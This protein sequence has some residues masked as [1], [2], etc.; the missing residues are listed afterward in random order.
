[1]VE[2]SFLCAALFLNEIHTPMK[3]HVDISKKTQRFLELCS[4]Q[5]K[6]YEK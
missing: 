5:L 3:F 4:T 6:N 1:M 2:L